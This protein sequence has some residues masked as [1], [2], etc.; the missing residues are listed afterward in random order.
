VP[1]VCAHVGH[2]GLTSR[3]YI[4]YVAR[5]E[6]ENNPEL[7]IRAYRNLN[8]NWPLVVVGGNTYRPSYVDELKLIAD[9]RVQ[10]MGAV[11]GDDYWA[12]QRNAGL[13]VFAGEIGGVHPALIEAMASGNA[14]LYLDTPANLETVCGCGISFQP[15]ESDLTSKMLHMMQSPEETMVLA[16]QAQDV[17][18]RN[19]NWETVTD[20]YESLFRNMIANLGRS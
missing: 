12:L 14:I 3:Q 1:T 8:T 2:F 20:Q 19:Y 15:V 18:Q 11:H 10:F 7:V 17:A 6:P 9:S 16:R 4:L 5:L 13:F